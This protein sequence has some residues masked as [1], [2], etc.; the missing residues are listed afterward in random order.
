MDIPNEL[1]LP[2]PP[3]LPQAGPK[4]PNPAIAV[5]GDQLCRVLGQL[6]TSIEKTTSVSNAYP[7]P[8]CKILDN[9]ETSVEQQRPII[10]RSPDLLQERFSRLENEIEHQLPMAP[11]HK[12][13]SHEE[14]VPPTQDG[15]SQM[16]RQSRLPFTPS[17][18]PEAFHR[19]PLLLRQHPEPMHRMSGHSTGIRNSGN[20]FDW[21]CNI[22][23]EWVSKDECDDCPDFEETDYDPVDKE[24][25]RCRHSFPTF[26]EEQNK[27]EDENTDLEEQTDE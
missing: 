1:P 26:F 13:D 24:D 17:Q 25:K 7:D 6:E 22:R 8:L 15:L 23:Q 19:E 20:G 16:N 5:S 2:E 11:K 14:I 3:A 12:E 21:Y 18:K 27:T 10:D 4:Q 9:L